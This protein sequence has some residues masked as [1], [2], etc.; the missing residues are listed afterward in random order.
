MKKKN[1]SFASV[2]YS[3]IYF[4]SCSVCFANKRKSDGTSPKSKP[5]FVNPSEELIRYGVHWYWIGMD[6][7]KEGLPKTLK[8]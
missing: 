8:P 6:I 3:N 7:S 2:A 1:V 4:D 5:G